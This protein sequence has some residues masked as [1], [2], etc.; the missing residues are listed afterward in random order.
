MR[1][2]VACEFSGIVRDAFLKKGH[3]VISCDLLPTEN[4]GPHYQGDIRD[5]LYQEWD[6]IIAHPPCTRLANSGVRWLGERNLWRD[7]EEGCAFF[8]LFLDH[9]CEKIAIENPLPHKYAWKKIGRKYDQL[10]QPWQFGHPE[11]KAICLWLKNLPKLRPTN[12]VSGREQRIHF[13]SGKDRAKN[14]SRFFP[15]VAAVMADTYGII[16]YQ[17]G[18]LF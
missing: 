16:P 13:M 8:K 4:P 18:L 15:G 3:D 14:R 17:K 2:L 1:I 10:I 7:L 12:V 11:T 9:P 6:M 5:I